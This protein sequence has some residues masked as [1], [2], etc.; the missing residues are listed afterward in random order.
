MLFQRLT[1]GFINLVARCRV[2]KST[3]VFVGKENIMPSERRP[4]RNLI[5]AVDFG[6]T[7][8]CARIYN[9]KCL[10]EAIL[11]SNTSDPEACW[12]VLCNL[13]QSV[14]TR[15]GIRTSDVYCLGLSV[16]RNTFLI[17]NR[18]TSVPVTRLCT[19]QEINASAYA[20]NRNNSQ[21]IK[22]LNRSGKMLYKVVPNAKFKMISHYKLTCI[23]AV[24]RL[25]HMFDE[26]PMLYEK[27]RDGE[28]V[29]GCLE[30]WL[31][32]RLTGG[33]AWCTDVSCTSATGAFDPSIPGLSPIILNF[34]K[35]SPKSFPAICPTSTFFGEIHCGPL[36]DLGGAA[37]RRR[38]RVTAIIGD[39]QAA[40][41]GEGCLSVGDAKLTL[42]TGAFLNVNIGSRVIPPN[43]GF[44]PV[45][46]WAQS[47]RTDSSLS[48]EVVPD[49]ELKNV[50]Y[51]IEGFNS[52][53]GSSLIKLKEAGYFQSY[54]ELEQILGTTSGS[55]DMAIETSPFFVPSSLG[56]RKVSRKRRTRSCEGEKALTF[57][58]TNTTL[59]DG[60]I[61]VGLPGPLYQRNLPTSTRHAV[62]FALMDSI[63]MSA[64]LLF[65][66][67]VNK[68]LA[69]DISV[70][71]LNGN[72]TQSD[73][74]MQRLADTLDL[75]VERSAISETCCLGAAIA[76][77]VGAGIWDTYAEAVQCVHEQNTR[78]AS[79][80]APKALK[81]RFIPNPASAAC[82][83]SRYFHWTSVCAHTLAAH[84]SEFT[85][86]KSSVALNSLLKF[87]K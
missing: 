51:L 55:F 11:P 52:D 68:E 53:A 39:S 22:A 7:H 10:A 66:K 19:W 78:L 15:S 65:V 6:S 45:V 23:F 4:L 31:L 30:T 56:L 1:I 26:D 38:V 79:S 74:L 60:G 41:L 82:M 34:L 27:C 67:G 8:A 75:P 69:S 64:R 42:G 50:T 73:W 77:G 54:T 25:A 29:Y 63:V 12:S 40:M 32:W 3:R 14:I 76:A 2:S 72:L 83:E 46:G 35:I 57:V 71:R 9:D 28:F 21:F 5:A 62:L 13:L 80:K 44:Y 86:R 49:T 18:E 37:K 81:T 36:G 48:C 87:T 61:F 33:R 16:Q 85:K 20:S 17:W 59:T 47:A 43:T 58:N 84:D 70:L 24:T